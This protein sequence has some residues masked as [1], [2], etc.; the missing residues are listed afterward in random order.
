MSDRV[1][2]VG[3]VLTVPTKFRLR[4]VLMFQIVITMPTVI[5]LSLTLC[6]FSGGL[7]QYFIGIAIILTRFGEAC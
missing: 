4:V 2:T 1:I 5:A 6:V 7:L 3:I